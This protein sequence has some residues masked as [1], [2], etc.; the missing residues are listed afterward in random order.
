MKIIRRAGEKGKKSAE[1]RG[2]SVS[3]RAFNVV[4]CAGVR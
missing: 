4:P 2:Y 3:A 1:N